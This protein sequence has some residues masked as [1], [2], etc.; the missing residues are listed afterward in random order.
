MKKYID[1]YEPGK[2]IHKCHLSA[3]F[4]A[5]IRD[6]NIPMLLHSVHLIGAKEPYNMFVIK[7]PTTRS[8]TV[9]LQTPKVTGLLDTK[10]GGYCNTIA[11]LDLWCLMFLDLFLRSST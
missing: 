11:F 7:P 2:M 8:V 3:D 4:I 6:G 1:S 10:L 5:P 9:P